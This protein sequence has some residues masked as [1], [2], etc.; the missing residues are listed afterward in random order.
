MTCSGDAEGAIDLAIETP[1]ENVGAVRTNVTTVDIFGERTLVQEELVYPRCVD[2]WAAFPEH[3][4]PDCAIFDRSSVEL[5][6][7]SCL[8]GRH[9]VVAGRSCGP[10]VREYASCGART[11]IEDEL[12]IAP[13]ACHG[14]RHARAWRTEELTAWRSPPRVVVRLP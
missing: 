12:R 14:P 5:Y 11:P 7:W 2:P 1:W 9:V 3:T 10:V 13:D 8:E 6:T 4:P